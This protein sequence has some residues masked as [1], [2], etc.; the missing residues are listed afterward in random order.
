MLDKTGGKR[1]N[2]NSVSRQICRLSQPK[3]MI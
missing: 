2:H 1:P 3:R